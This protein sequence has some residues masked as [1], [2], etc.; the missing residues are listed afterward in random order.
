MS[1]RAPCDRCTPGSGTMGPVAGENTLPWSWSRSHALDPLRRAIDLVEWSARSIPQKGDLARARN[2]RARRRWR[3]FAQGAWTMSLRRSSGPCR[4]SDDT[5]EK[6]GGSD[7]SRHLRR[8]KSRSH[9]P[10]KEATR[11]HARK[12]LRQVWGCRRADC[13]RP[14]GP[15]RPACAVGN[16][17]LRSSANMRTTSLPSR[18][19]SRLSGDSLP[20]DVPATKR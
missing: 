20:S 19:L 15:C 2:S 9:A 12:D 8:V 18:V 4:R 7:A 16:R 14:I 17:Q 10:R 5:G 6:H 11:R 1:N 13:R 3:T